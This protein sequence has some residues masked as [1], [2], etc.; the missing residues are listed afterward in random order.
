VKTSPVLI[1]IFVTLLFSCNGGASD[2]VSRTK[3]FITA[4][5]NF[6][7]D[8]AREMVTEDYLPMLENIEKY[9]NSKSGEEKAK[10]IKEASERKYIYHQLSADDS[11]ATVVA[12]AEGKIMA[13]IQIE[14]HLVKR[15]KKWL[16]DSQ[17]GE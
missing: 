6:R 4:V 9:S 11:S 13:E 17:Q 14:F 7:F 16:I 15:D 1:L 3:D 10:Y 12:T 2:P 5:D 8:K